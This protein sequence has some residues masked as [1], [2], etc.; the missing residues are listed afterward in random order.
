MKSSNEHEKVQ[1]IDKWYNAIIEKYWSE[2]PLYYNSAY[3]LTVFFLNI[4]ILSRGTFC[5]VRAD[6]YSFINVNLSPLDVDDWSDAA[7]M[8]L[9]EVKAREI[10]LSTLIRCR[11]SLYQR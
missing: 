6:L 8:M 7:K 10:R 1:M 9:Y 4:E 3:H 2:D 5:L 11:T